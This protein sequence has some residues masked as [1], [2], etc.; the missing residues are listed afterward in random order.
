MPCS[1]SRDSEDAER[2][3]VKV[4]FLTDAM[5]WLCRELEKTNN[6]TH[7]KRADIVAWWSDHRQYD[8]TKGRA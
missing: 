1:D 7:L 4:K 6:T 5:C 2:N 8:R 3:A